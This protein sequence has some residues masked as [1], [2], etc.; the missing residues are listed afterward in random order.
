MC[1]SVNQ[2][3]LGG[4]WG[5]SHAFCRPGKCVQRSQWHSHP[6]YAHRAAHARMSVS[7]TGWRQRT[8]RP[9]W[10]WIWPAIRRMCVCVICHVHDLLRQL[11]AF[12]IYIIIGL[13]TLTPPTTAF[14]VNSLHLL[15][16]SVACLPPFHV[17]FATVA[18]KG[19]AKT[20]KAACTML[21]KT[22]THM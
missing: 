18:P 2:E 20:L 8:K 14:P 19:N 22:T 21:S 10:C 5:Y 6:T 13:S 11:C 4:F 7:P 9:T 3:C 15:S 1:V 16:I 17:P 12:L